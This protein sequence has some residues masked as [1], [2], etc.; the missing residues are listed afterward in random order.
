MPRRPCGRCSRMTTSTSSTP[1]APPACP[2]A[3]FSPTARSPRTAPRS[4]RCLT[5]ERR[6]NGAWWQRPCVTPARSGAPLPLA[7]G[8]SLAVVGAVN[9]VE[10]VRALDEDRIGYAALAPS[11]LHMCLTDVPDVAIRRYRHLRLIHLGSAPS[12]D[13]CC[14]GRSRCSVATS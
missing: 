6:V 4:P 10:L 11:I 12:P 7:G 14:T 8:A 2:R 3:P 9:P 5:G 1:A 13:R